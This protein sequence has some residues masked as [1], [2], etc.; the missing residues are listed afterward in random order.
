M[1]Q[2]S[3]SSREERSERHWKQLRNPGIDAIP[4]N[5]GELQQASGEKV[6]GR[7][8]EIKAKQWL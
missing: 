1:Q 5:A 2:K 3:S 7:K 8:G 4:S 6:I